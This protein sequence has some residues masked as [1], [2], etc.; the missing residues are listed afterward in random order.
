MTKEEAKEIQD[1]IDIEGFDYAM[2]YY[3]NWEHINDGKFHILR[4]T[5]KD[6]NKAFADYLIEQG[7]DSEEF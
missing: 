3:S 6:A 5:V 2:F 4:Q 1:R 7:V